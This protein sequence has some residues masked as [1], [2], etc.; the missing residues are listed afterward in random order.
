MKIKK[1]EI[2]KFP[3]RLM[4]P[5][6]A[7]LKSELKRLKRNKKNIEKEDPF[8][9]ERRITDNASP[10]TEAEEQFGHARTSAIRDQLDKKIVQTRKALSRAR[11]GKYGI[12]ENCGKMIDTDRLIVYPQATLCVKCEAKKEK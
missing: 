3:S 12:C 1:T 5:V 8:S 4:T 11:I 7:F 6:V 9:D 2:S 10:D